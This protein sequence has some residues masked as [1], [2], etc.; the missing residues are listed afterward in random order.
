MK[1][2]VSL[3]FM[4][5]MTIAVF[6]QVTTSS[7]NGSVSDAKGQPLLGATVKAIHVPTGTVYAT[8]TQKTGKFNIGGMRVG[9]PYTI[10]FSFI[11]YN[12]EK[13]TGVSLTL[14]EDATYNV[15]LNESSQTMSDIIVVGKANPVFNSNR[16]GA[17]EV[18]TK[19]LM[20]K[21]PT[22]NR[23]LSDFTK[24][25]PMSSGNNFGGTSYRFNNVTVDGASFNNSFGLGSS[26]GASG[27][28]PISLEAIEQVQVMIAPYDVRN[29]AFTGAGINSV[30]KSGTN[31]WEASAYFYKKS[32]SM[33]GWRQKDDKPSIS[34]F[35]SNQYGVSVGGPIIKNKL[36]FF[37]NGELD[38]QET[39]INF[40][41]RKNANEAIT[42]N[43]SKPTEGQL[44]EISDFLMDKFKY[45]PGTYS[46]ENTP[47]QADRIT[48]R[49]DWNINSKNTLSV[50]YFYLKSF[51]TNMPSSSGA[52]AGG[53]GPNSESIP[54]SS[55]YYRTNNNFNIFMADLNTTINDR[56]SNTL[57][58]GYS[59]L[60]DFREMD[61]GFFPQV[62]ILDGQGRSFTTFGTEANSYNNMLDSDIFQIQDN[63]TWNINKHQLTF[64]TQ[65]DLRKF[66]NGYANSF[67]GQF[68]YSSFADFKTEIETGELKSTY[69]KQAFSKKGD[70]F[71]F[72]Y[73]DVLSLGFYVQDKWSIL[74]NFNVTLGIRVDT[75]IFLTDL[76]RNPEAE[77]IT[78]QGGTKIDV[79][80]Y[81]GAK[82]LFSP[83]IGFNWDVLK[84]KT[85]QV[86]GGTGIFSGTPPYVWLSNQAGN[87]GMLFG[88]LNKRP[89]DGISNYQPSETEIGRSKMDMA[90]TDP[91]FKYP[92]LWKT[93]VALD[94][95]FGNGWIA[96]VEM[97]YNKDVN[98]IY[99][100]NIGL[101][102]P[103]A[104]VNEPGG[105]SR[106]YFKTRATVND[107]GDAIVSQFI[108]DKTE[109][110]VLMKNTSKGHSLYTTFQLQ[111][112]FLHGPLKGLY[113][114]GSFSFGR[115][116]GVT[117]GSSS[118]AS[119]AWKYRPAV[120]PNAEEVSF[121]SGSF[122]DR[123]LLQVAYRANWSKNAAT[124]VGVIYQRYR[125]FRYSY[126]YNGDLN[127]DGQNMNDL[128]YVPANRNDF[129]IVKDK[130]K[131]ASGNPIVDNRTPD[132]IW[133]QIDAFI[134]QDSYL[135]NR[136]GQYSERNG[137]V[138]PYAN[139]LDL[140]ITHDIKVPL[141]NGKVNTLRFSFDIANVLNLL[142]KD[143]GV[144]MTTIYGSSN[145]PQ[146]QFLKMIDAPSAVNNYTP[147][148]TMPLNSGKPATK[149][150][151][152]YNGGD[153]R[154][155][156]QF[157]IKYMFN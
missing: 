60:R 156:M 65:S 143:W 33:T 97:L 132:E 37:I 13:M 124:S 157:G 32:P 125:P 134:D 155:A 27:T 136:R 20:T 36:F 24:L 50:K 11:G 84:D 130:G 153:S 67:A 106:P 95:T 90:V 146:Y 122:N 118:V 150:F 3:V 140:N 141:K 19:D 137:A 77:Q 114:N 31:N 80:K 42:G 6:A 100:T 87:N 108:N 83:R 68:T 4:M 131:D 109:N 135:K 126:T 29:G 38:R 25:T 66:K 76:E 15:K 129:N 70:E 35:I 44:N 41:A 18:I 117:D 58:V 94:Y 113:L 69:F 152:D 133:N 121:S 53:R 63:F 98:A 52:P 147:S 139:Q 105:Q 9:G 26:L 46:V 1:K 73:I 116:K 61:G 12:T 151:K 138:I 107:K 55:C 86:R 54:F 110:V 72:A 47:T 64:G 112:D 62:D 71:P 149:T 119:S 102:D 28:E 34:E 21:L 49:L 74:P 128:M 59:A 144:Q 23:S 7:I 48:A 88:L 56:M 145:S 115:S 30:T 85:L 16:T 154:W 127:G 99:H 104:Y 120:N 75:P 57:K 89:F 5:V 96:T 103:I 22:L 45:N 51:N 2:L 17:Q 10:E 82:P 39:P 148:F 92:Q 142:N 101:N 14:G 81:P 123:L 91:D 43:L 111:K 40:R 79:S 8:S 93:N 78:F